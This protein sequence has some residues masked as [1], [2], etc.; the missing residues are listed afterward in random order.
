MLA[1]MSQKV[2]SLKFRLYLS[3]RNIV[4]VDRLSLNIIHGKGVGV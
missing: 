2:V 4:H 1:K 3:K